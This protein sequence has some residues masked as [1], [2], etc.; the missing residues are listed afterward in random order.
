MAKTIKIVLI[1]QAFLLAAGIEALVGELHG[2][3]VEQVYHGSEHHLTD[4]VLGHKPDMIIINPHAIENQLLSVIKIFQQE[5]DI[6]LVGLLSTKVP[7]NIKSRFAHY[8]NRDEGKFDLL[9]GLKKI[10]GNS[11]EKPAKKNRILSNREIELLKQV[12]LGHTNQEIADKLFLSVH[13][14]MTH[15]KNI[16][17][18]LGIKTVSGLTVYSLMNNLVDIREVENRG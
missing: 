9:E 14:V 4:K 8:L 5:P 12:C 10:I 11:L 18:K 2:V 13:T 15:R 3:F 17:K 16:T 1:E 6:K 7:D